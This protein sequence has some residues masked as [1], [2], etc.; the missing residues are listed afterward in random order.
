MTD[1]AL[2]LGLKPHLR[3]HVIS[4]NEVA[5]IG[6]RERYVIR[7]ELYVA[8]LP[9]LDGS[10]NSDEIATAVADLYAPEQV[11][12]ALTQLE[13]KGYTGNVGTDPQA[14]WWSAHGVTEAAA[15]EISRYSIAIINAGTP[16]VVQG[17]SLSCQRP[18]P[19]CSWVA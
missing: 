1:T 6:E 9:L 4:A 8:L 15:A 12:Y 7:G 10:R 3:S 11:Y 14:A 17:S 5:L 18:C 16:E 19:T 13:A 2:R